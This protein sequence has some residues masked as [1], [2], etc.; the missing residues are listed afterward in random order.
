MQIQARN[1]N[2][3]DQGA[4]QGVNKDGT[5]EFAQNICSVNRQSFSNLL[6]GTKDDPQS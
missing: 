5:L 6:Y 2:T 1:Q 3:Y 4:F